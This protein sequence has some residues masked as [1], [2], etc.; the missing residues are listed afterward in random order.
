MQVPSNL[1]VSKIK[2][3]AWYICFAVGV[4]GVISACT[5]AVH[6]FGALMACRFF[7]GFVEAVFFPGM[8][9]TSERESE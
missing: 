4:W 9:L 5:A 6:S 3:P 7:L 1:L 2:Y 8:I